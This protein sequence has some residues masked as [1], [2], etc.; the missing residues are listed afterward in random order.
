MPHLVNERH[1]VRSLLAA[2]HHRVEPVV[3]PELIQHLEPKAV[4][5]ELDVCGQVIG[6]A[7]DAQMRLSQI[8]RR[9]H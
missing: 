2:E 7:D 3:V 6:W 4:T 9:I 1:V 8:G 5:V